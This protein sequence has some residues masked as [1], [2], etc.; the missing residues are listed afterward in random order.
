MF[1][2]A[3][4]LLFIINLRFPRNET[5]SS[6]L[7]RRYGR[8]VLVLFREVERHDFKKRKLQCD[9]Q[10]L[11]RCQEQD[12]IPNF[13]KFKLANSN[14]QRSRSYRK[15]QRFFL[16]SEIKNKEKEFKAA[17]KKYS[18]L[19]TQL[20]SKVSWLD[21]NHLSN[22]IERQNVKSISRVEFIQSSKLTKLG[23][24]FHANLPLDAVIFNYSNR[25]LSDL[26]KSALSRG[27]KYAIQ[28]TKPKFVNHFLSF[29]KLH[30][31]LSSHE[32]HKYERGR[33]DHFK[34][35]FRNLAFES[36]YTKT[37]QSNNNLS[38][39]EFQAYHHSN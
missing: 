3:L 15:C 34:S 36:Y 18:E 13:L 16:S 4:V 22:I 21:I 2:Y 11:K 31:S 39:D 12:L 14:L 24:N 29:E 33:F 25:V 20:Q 30:K 35:S 1:V 28:P 8:P 9:L 27:L 19:Y 10:F 17:N 6:I 7:T 23:Y 26:E 37:H 38:K 5:I 32:F